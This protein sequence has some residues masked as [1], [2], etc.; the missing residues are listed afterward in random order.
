MGF[1]VTV[2]FFAAVLEVVLLVVFLVV[3]VVVPFPAVVVP[4]R[5]CA[6]ASSA[7]ALQAKR[8]AN[9]SMIPF[10]ASVLV[11]YYRAMNLFSISSTDTSLYFPET[12]V[13]VSQS[14]SLPR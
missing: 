8:A 10:I 13:R 12:W 7:T 9:V 14:L 3:C 5:V 4:R 6:A 1:G 2:F 11:G